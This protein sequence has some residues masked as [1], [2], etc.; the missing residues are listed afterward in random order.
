LRYDI[1]GLLSWMQH[2]HMMSSMHSIFAD[3]PRRQDKSRHRTFASDTASI[4]MGVLHPTVPGIFP[5][6]T[7]SA[8]DIGASPRVVDVVAEFAP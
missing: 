3:M 1:N 4:V 2:A 6:S 5:L 8:F 7:V